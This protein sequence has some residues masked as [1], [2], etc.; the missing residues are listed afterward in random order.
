MGT[1][2]KSDEEIINA[3]QGGAKKR[4]DAL[5]QI[6]MNKNLNKRI[7]NFLIH[8]KA[9]PKDKD[10]ILTEAILIFDRNIRSN[11]FKQESN[12][13][14]Y[15]F[16]IATY[17]WISYKK[18][19]SHPHQASD[20]ELLNIKDVQ[21]P[22]LIVIQRELKEQ[23]WQILNQMGEKCKK[24]LEYWCGKYNYSEIAKLMDL[25]SESSARKMKYNCKKKLVE[26]VRTK[27]DL[28]P[29]EYHGRI[30]K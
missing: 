19:K 20:H 30:I 22:E 29:S 15:L 18:N 5:A 13:Y 16:S 10:E 17:Y 23:L 7:T 26:L 8:K 2:F 1:P 4:R 14:T 12:I 9:D 24:I 6:Y 25:G 21:N 27:P 28:I 11:K 3:I